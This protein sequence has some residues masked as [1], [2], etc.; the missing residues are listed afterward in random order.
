M[1]RADLLFPL[2]LWLIVAVLTCT[3]VWLGRHRIGEHIPHF[4][5]AWSWSRGKRLA[6]LAGIFSAGEAVVMSGIPLPGSE[7]IP[8]LARL[9][10]IGAI[11]GIAFYLRWRANRENKRAP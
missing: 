6:V 10:L 7:K 3:C 8:V 9:A 4:A 11:V 5:A 1:N 2:S